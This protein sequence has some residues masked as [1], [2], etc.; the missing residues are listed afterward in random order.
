MFLFTEA[1]LAPV[2]ALLSLRLLCITFLIHPM[3]NWS[4]TWAIRHMAIKYSPA[5][6]TNSIRTGCMVGFRDFLKEPR[7]DTTLL[8]WGIPRRRYLRHWGWR[9]PQNI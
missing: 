5:E 6:E 2:W 4:G 8:A 7:A 1:T 9:P 3:I